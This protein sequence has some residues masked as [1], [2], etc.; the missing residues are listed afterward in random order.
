MFHHDGP[1]VAGSARCLNSPIQYKQKHTY[2][3]CR[4]TQHAVYLQQHA[5]AGLALTPARHPFKHLTPALAGNCQQCRTGPIVT[6][7]P[8]CPSQSRRHDNQPPP[9]SPALPAVPAHPHTHNT[10]SHPH[11]ISTATAGL[12]HI[13]SLTHPPRA[14]APPLPATLPCMADGPR[15]AQGSAP[16]A[17]PAP[18]RA[19][20]ARGAPGT[21]AAYTSLP[22]PIDYTPI[23]SPCAA[24]AHR[25]G[26]L[27]KPR[28]HASRSIGG[29]QAT[30]LSH[31]RR[32]GS[33]RL[34]HAP[35]SH[36]HHT[37]A[38]T[39]GSSCN[40]RVTLM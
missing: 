7:A 30:S 14:E 2:F 23:A 20:V 19:A 15:A 12:H 22:R 35:D 31:Q 32:H 38:C 3:S 27:A 5:A 13:P 11:T 8:Q 18:H 1:G 21:T 10:T 9:A 26:S 29:P 17:T 25:R 6:P 37:P 4:D 39:T 40:P 16:T 33:S 24:V 36:K 34:P 28:H